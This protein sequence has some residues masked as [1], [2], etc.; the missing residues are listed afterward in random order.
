MR[1]QTSQLGETHKCT[2]RAKPTISVV[3]PTLGRSPWLDLAIESVLNQSYLPI[4]CIVVDDR[5]ASETDDLHAALLSLE[6]C[7]SEALD[8][9]DQPVSNRQVRMQ[10]YHAAKAS[11]SSAQALQEQT[12]FAETNSAQ[13]EG[14]QNKPTQLAQPLHTQPLHTQIRWLRTYGS[15]ASA[16]RN[17]GVAAAQGEWIAFLDD[18]DSWHLDKLAQQ[19][20]AAL[21]SPALFPVLSCRMQVKTNTAQYDFPRQAYDGCEPLAEYLFCR[22]GFSKG[23]GWMQTSTLL[24]PRALLLAEPWHE[25]L[26]L[27]QDWDWL[28][29]VTARTD[30]SLTML[31]ETLAVYRTEDARPSISRTPD[32]QASLNWIRSHQSS[33]SPRAVSWFIAIECVWRARASGAN[34]RGWAR[35]LHSFLT[36]GRPNLPATLAFAAFALFPVG[37]RKQLRN[38][39]WSDQNKTKKMHLPWEKLWAHSSS[40]GSS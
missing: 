19:I 12:R 26:K 29:R 2:L 8:R 10:A 5:A 33:M 23:K 11:M 18:D 13:I 27:H 25:G 3:V 6:A 37:W 32:W 7:Q 28:L 22:K 40:Q 4:E 14:F 16:A 39:C 30:V 34:H 15:G 20:E 1:D 35:L 31:D 21:R 9:V 38:F 36:E 17:A 24:A